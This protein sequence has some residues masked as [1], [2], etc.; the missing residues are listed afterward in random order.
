MLDSKMELWIPKSKMDFIKK[1]SRDMVGK[2]TLC[3]ANASCARL[4]GRLELCFP[5]PKM[6]FIISKVEIWSKQ[7]ALQMLRVLGSLV[8]TKL[9]SDQREENED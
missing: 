4:F 5:K 1:L 7:C 8:V 2:Q 3:F 6:D 9:L